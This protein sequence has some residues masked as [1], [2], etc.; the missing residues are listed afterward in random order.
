M[1]T[2]GFK[3]YLTGQGTP[4]EREKWEDILLED[5]EAL[6]LYMESL[7]EWKDGIPELVDQ[8]SFVNKVMEGLP[9]TGNSIEPQRQ[10][11]K[12]WYERTLFHY[13]VAASLTL[14]FMSSGV[15][16]RLMTGN[17]DVVV[18]NDS[19]GSYSEQVIQATSGWLEQIMTDGNQ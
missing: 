2:N 19:G 18:P 15:F 8:V 4:A 3:T 11:R 16:D 10:T 1:G 5:E 13:A 12:R 7:D 6:S 17:M 14:L 9:V